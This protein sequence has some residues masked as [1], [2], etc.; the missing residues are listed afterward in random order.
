MPISTLRD[1]ARDCGVSSATV[2]NVLNNTSRP[3]HARTR[4]RVLEAVKRLNYFPNAMARGLQGQRLNMIGILFGVIEPEIITN[5]YAAQI[6]KGIFSAAADG[7]YNVVFWTSRWKS[8]AA[9][10]AA[11]RDRRVDG[12]IVL[13]PTL[14]SDIVG[15]VA[16]HGIPQVV[17]SSR[18]VPEGVAYADVDNRA[19][20]RIATEHVIALGH[21][22]IAHI[23][24]DI[25]QPSV[26]DRRQGFY[27]AILGANLS[28]PREYDIDSWYM[29]EECKPHVRAL[30]Q[31]PQRPTAIVTGSDN[32][33][34]GILQVAQE[35]GIAVPGQLSVTGFDDIPPATLVTPQLTTVRQ[36]LTEI[37]GHATQMLIAQIEEATRPAEKWVAQPKLVVRGSTGPVPNNIL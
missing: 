33:A 10:A 15:G 34:V 23:G 29:V 24:G 14:D 22:R 3:V 37:G 13:A 2:S 30:L 11:L 16:S 7:G 19:G 6:V 12:Y 25:G 1:V 17:I 18:Y 5:P 27:D 28:V 36:P 26:A 35:M 20:L 32:I 8:A 21:T 9:S 31:L 4:A